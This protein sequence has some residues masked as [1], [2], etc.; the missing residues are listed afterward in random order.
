MAQGKVALLLGQG[1]ED[2]EA[3]A[4]VKDEAERAAAN[5]EARQRV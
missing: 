1:F 3:S 4:K 5:G 2:S